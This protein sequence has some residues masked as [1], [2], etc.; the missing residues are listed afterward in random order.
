[1]KDDIDNTKEELSSEEKLLE[2]GYSRGYLCNTDRSMNN[3]VN[4]L[5]NANCLTI[6]RRGRFEDDGVTYNY[7][8]YYKKLNKKDDLRG[9]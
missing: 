8:I 9:R 6:V 4:T 7:A 2:A 5:E 1:M 3:I